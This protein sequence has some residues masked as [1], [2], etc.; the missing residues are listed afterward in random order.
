M[1]K[2]VTNPTTRINHLVFDYLKQHI[3]TRHKDPTNNGVSWMITQVFFNVV[4]YMKQ[5]CYNGPCG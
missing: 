4:I 2:L 1:M 5:Q 3:S